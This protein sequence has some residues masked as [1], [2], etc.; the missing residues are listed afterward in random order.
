MTRLGARLMV[1]AAFAGCVLASPPFDG[2]RT[3][4]LQAQ[5]ATERIPRAPDGHP[6][7]SGI[8]QALSTAAWDLEHHNA[9]ESV[10][11]GI[12]V[13]EGG[14]IPYQAW[15]LAKRKEHSENRRT[16]DPL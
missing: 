4:G 11:A 8:W 15:A 10:P 6:D 9:E 1:A 16:L 13:V 12:S 3:A 14:D 7:L 5:A 2:L